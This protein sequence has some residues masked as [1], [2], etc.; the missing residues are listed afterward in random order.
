MLTERDKD[1]VE[2][3][4]NNQRINIQAAAYTLYNEL[5]PNNKKP[6]SQRE[7][8]TKFH[9]NWRIFENIESEN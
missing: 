8:A 4:V 9:D 7:F 3:I 2:V 5:L 1:I 6:I